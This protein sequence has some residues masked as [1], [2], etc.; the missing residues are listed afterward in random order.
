MQTLSSLPAH[1]I[2]TALSIFTSELLNLHRGQGLDLYWRDDES[3]IPPTECAYLK[4]VANKTGGLFRLAIRLMCL[5]SETS[6]NYDVVAPLVEKLGLIFQIRDDYRNLVCD[7][8]GFSLSLCFFFFF[9]SFTTLPICLTYLYSPLIH[10][11]FSKTVPNNDTWGLVYIPKRPLRRPNRRQILLFNNPRHSKLS[12][13]R[14]RG[15][16]RYAHPRHLI[17]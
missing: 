14:R 16:E 9:Y 1:T 10:R 4:M 7:D 2:P 15:A 12:P 11:F 6:Y 8:V 13:S 17:P 5:V 3:R